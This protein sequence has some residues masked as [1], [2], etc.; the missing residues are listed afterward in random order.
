MLWGLLDTQDDWPKRYSN[1]VRQAN[2]QGQGEPRQSCENGEG[3][4]GGGATLQNL[5]KWSSKAQYN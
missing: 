2:T 1:S 4:V 3:G 5:A